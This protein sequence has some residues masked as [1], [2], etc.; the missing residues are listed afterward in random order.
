M[1]AGLW[2]GEARGLPAHF[3]HPCWQPSLL[4]TLCSAHMASKHIT[5]AEI[6]FWNLKLQQLPQNTKTHPWCMQTPAL[7][8][9]GQLSSSLTRFCAMGLLSSMGQ[10]YPS[11][12]PLLPMLLRGEAFFFSLT[13]FDHLLCVCSP[14]F[15]LTSAMLQLFM[16]AAQRRTCMWNKNYPLP[17]PQ[18]YLAT[19]M[20]FTL[21]HNLLSTF[22]GFPC[23]LII[24]LL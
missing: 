20:V 14:S 2:H 11:H 4:F 6:T 22:P 24:C 12:Y 23:V 3:I 1:C 18:P 7:Q 15:I 8:H 9:H 19:N 17:S 5:K 10:S 21:L 13:I 16:D